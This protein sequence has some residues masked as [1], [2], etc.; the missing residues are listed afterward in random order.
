VAI[1]AAGRNLGNFSNL[2]IMRVSA[3]L[4][5]LLSGEARMF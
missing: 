3:S 1:D 4:S 2:I 5:A